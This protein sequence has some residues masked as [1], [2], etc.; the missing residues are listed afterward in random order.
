MPVTHFDLTLARPLAGGRAFG[1]VG[2]YDELKGR[3]RFVLDPTHAANVRITDLDR[4]PRNRDGHAEFAAD[5]SILLPT[6]RARGNG[7]MIV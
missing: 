6:E 7:R 5:V 1:D 2:P 4:A 3:L